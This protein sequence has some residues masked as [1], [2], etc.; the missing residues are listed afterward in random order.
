MFKH[1]VTLCAP[2]CCAFCGQTIPAGSKAICDI[3]LL[4]LR[5]YHRPCH[6]DLLQAQAWMAALPPHLT[7]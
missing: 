1:T 4:G 3:T 2:R 5:Y 6:L 7:D